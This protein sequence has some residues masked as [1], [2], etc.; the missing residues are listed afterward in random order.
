MRNKA[1]FI[2]LILIFQGYPIF[3]QANSS[4]IGSWQNELG[5]VLVID[6]IKKD[7]QIMG[8]YKSSTGVDGRIFPLQGWINRDDQSGRMAIAFTVRWEGYGSI[9]SWTGY[10]DTDEEG[11]YIKTLWHLVRPQPELPWERIITN[12]SLFR[13]LSD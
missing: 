3:S 10:L 9:T 1:L 11:T 6:S 2:M 8:I 13:R 4:L 7:H 12:S 5:S